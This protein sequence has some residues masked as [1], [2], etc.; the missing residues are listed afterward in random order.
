MPS[1]VL[2][3]IKALTFL[4]L[5]SP[6]VDPQAHFDIVID[7]VYEFL[8]RNDVNINPAPDDFVLYSFMAFDFMSQAVRDSALLQ[9]ELR[10]LLLVRI[11]AFIRCIH[12]STLPLFFLSYVK[13]ANTSHSLFDLP[14]SF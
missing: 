13:S 11:E 1:S 7:L 5:N 6:E 14:R 9:S 10:A 2:V 4:V 3:A 8:L 12:S